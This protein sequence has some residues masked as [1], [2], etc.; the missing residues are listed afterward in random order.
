M[1]KL[2]EYCQYWNEKIK[3]IVKPPRDYAEFFETKAFYEGIKPDSRIKNARYMSEH[4]ELKIRKSIKDG[5]L[6]S[7]KP[8]NLDGSLKPNSLIIY[9]E[10]ILTY[11]RGFD[12]GSFPP[13]YWTGYPVKWKP[14]KK[15]HQLIWCKIKG[16][17]EI[18]DGSPH[19]DDCYICGQNPLIYQC[20]YGDELWKFYLDLPCLSSHT[21][22]KLFRMDFSYSLK[23]LF[24]DYEYDDC[25][26]YVVPYQ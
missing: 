19:K 25:A 12:L 17:K 8:R 11:P 22:A 1:E 23:P 24:H 21:D 7:I 16:Y 26:V 20:Y 9:S 15:V 6:V 13:D 14:S 18:C 2:H 4:L 5:D 3:T 10:K